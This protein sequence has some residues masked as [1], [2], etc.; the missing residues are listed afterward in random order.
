MHLQHPLSVKKTHLRGT[1]TFILNAVLHAD[2]AFLHNGSVTVRFSHIIS[3][4]FKKRL[5]EQ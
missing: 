3:K 4:M 2:S 1:I 5:I